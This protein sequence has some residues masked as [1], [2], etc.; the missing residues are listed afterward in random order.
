MNRGDL[1]QIIDKERYEKLTDTDQTKVV[2][3]SNGN[4]ESKKMLNQL[5]M[6]RRI[7]KQVEFYLI[8]EDEDICIAYP[9][10][11]TDDY[12]YIIIFTT[13]Q[14]DRIID[15]VNGVV[16]IKEELRRFNIFPG[17]G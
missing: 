11:N 17:R 14:G 12:P 1:M 16:N 7:F 3:F 4:H 10:L 5:E 9:D 13:V 2:L 6:A 15:Y 8:E